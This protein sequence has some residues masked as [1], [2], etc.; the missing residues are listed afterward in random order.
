MLVSVANHIPAR[1][2]LRV[3]RGGNWWHEIRTI[4]TAVHKLAAVAL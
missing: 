1:C 3:Q 4:E 2:F